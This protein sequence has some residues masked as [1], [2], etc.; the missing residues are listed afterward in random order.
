[1]PKLRAL[2]MKAA[3]ARWEE[4][5]DRRNWSRTVTG[6]LTRVYQGRRVTVFGPRDDTFGWCI[7]STVEEVE[8]GE[9]YDSVEE[10]MT[11]LGEALGLSLL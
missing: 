9:R 2:K 11:A 7:S 3:L 5:E 8:F 1:M 4:F 10:A 6:N